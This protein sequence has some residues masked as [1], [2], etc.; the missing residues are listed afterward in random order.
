MTKTILAK[1]TAIARPGAP[2]LRRLDWAIAWSL[3]VAA[4][5]LH[6]SF[7]GHA[8]ALWRDEVNSVNVA[9]RHSLGEMANDSFPVLMPALLRGWM[10]L[11]CGDSDTSM[12]WLGLLIGLGLLI[13][14]WVGVWSGRRSPPTLSLVLFGLNS[15]VIIYGDSLRAF[16][17]GSLLVVL[18]TAALCAFLRKPTWSRTGLLTTTAVLSVQ[19][20]FQNVILVA[21]VCVAG[22]A[23]CWRRRASQ[24]AVRILIASLMA[25]VSLLPYLSRITPLWR[26]TPTSG[27]STLRT[28]FRPAIALDSLGTA[29]GFPLRPYIWVWG[30]LALAVLLLAGMS[31][32]T[33]S[34][35]SESESSEANLIDLPL[36][37]AVSL[38]VG[39]GGFGAFLWWAALRTQPW[40]FLPPMALAAICFE[41]GLPKFDDS[42]AGGLPRL[43]IL[44]LIALTA[45]LAIPSAWRGVHWRF[46]NVDLLARR[47]S[48]ESAPGD[49]VLVTPWNRGISFARYFRAPVQWETI[50]PLSDHATH[51]YD[52]LQSQTQAKQVM[53][54]LFERIS[55][56]L[57]AGSRVWVV[58][59]IDLPLAR[60]PVPRDL[61]PPPREHTGWS[62][63]PYV[64][65][66]AAQAAQF[67]V[68]HS[69][70]FVEV[71]L[72]D[73]QPINSN[74]DLRLW[75]AEG[76]EP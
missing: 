22:W 37:S 44:G 63:G 20:L 74:E 15:T 38:F 5:W 62:A 61:G 24:L 31:W 35:T 71:P 49:F 23:V 69:H 67:L 42:G 59:A 76:W 19:A 50:P 29:I 60:A 53:R 73:A 10:G 43:V 45:L 4:L 7:S 32:G 33:N 39:L 57:R 75:V 70:T 26:T 18:F 30:F 68:N 17:L 16:G 6:F 34:S 21:A 41:L 55:T 8:G 51:R 47:L 14:L 25:A 66:W 11:G 65:R 27:I 56:A 13:A 1:L 40:Y 72:A 48:A 52:L 36:V 54:P 58:G 3:T 28:E 2:V 12:R 46:T 9:S 64:R